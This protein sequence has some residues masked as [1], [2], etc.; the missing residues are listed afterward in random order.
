MDEK[1]AMGMKKWH[2]ILGMA[3]MMLAGVSLWGQKIP[4]E[5]P[6]LIVGITVSGMQYDYLSV[7]WNKFGD[8]GFKLMGRPPEYDE[9]AV[10]GAFYGSQIGLPSRK[11]PE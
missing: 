4:P 9:L 1:Q 2:R 3:G 8:G 7:Y 5:K 11:V 6:K 10:C